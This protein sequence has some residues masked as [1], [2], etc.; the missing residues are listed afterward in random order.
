MAHKISLPTHGDPRGK[1]TVIDKLLPFD[2]KRI[3]F[4]Y[5]V[6]AER[7]GHRH[8]ACQMA[9]VA[10]NGIVKVYCDNGSKEE[11]FELSSPSE[12]LIVP[13][14][15]WHTMTFEKGAVLAVFASHHYDKND[16]IFE[17]YR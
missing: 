4:I 16:Y 8:H 11:N 9:M 7:G 10:L 3:F 5:D 13:P 2:V 12:A 15:D 17:G 6:S 14:E 1:L